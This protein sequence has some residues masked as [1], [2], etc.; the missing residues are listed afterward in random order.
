MVEKWYFFDFEL[1][2]SSF[3]KLFIDFV[4]MS[5]HRWD[6]DVDNLFLLLLFTLT[7]KITN[8]LFS[9]LNFFFSHYILAH[10]SWGHGCNKIIY[11]NNKYFRKLDVGSRNVKCVMLRCM[12]QNN[13]FVQCKQT[14]FYEYGFGLGKDL[15]FSS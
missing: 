5:L 4:S 10:R 8:K 14:F 12:Q 7:I 11:F 15:R 6:W 2:S 1:S 13:Y 9:F 3:F